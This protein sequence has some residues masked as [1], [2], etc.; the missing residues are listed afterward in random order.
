MSKCFRVEVLNRAMP[1][2]WFALRNLRLKYSKYAA[3]ET[4]PVNLF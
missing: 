4:N 2:F 1:C 3:C